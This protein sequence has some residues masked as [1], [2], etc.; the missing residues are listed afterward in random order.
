MKPKDKDTNMSNLNQKP[1]SPRTF[2]WGALSLRLKLVLGNTLITFLAVAGMGYYVYDRAQ[3]ANT[4]LSNQLYISVRQ[5]AEDK[6]T[7]TSIDEATALNNFFTSMSKDITTLGNTAQKLLSQEPLLNSGVYW[8][9][10]TALS[11]LPNGSWDN[12]NTEPASVFMPAKVDLSPE[13]T[14]E[15]NTIRQMDF[16]APTL[17]N[18]N[19]DAVAIYFG[20]VSGETIYYPNI[21]LASLVPA[22]F[23]VTQRP[24]FVAAT[25]IQDPDRKAVW[26]DPYL[27]A[28]RHG[29]IITVSTPVYDSGNNFRGVVAMDIQLNKITA[30]V[31]NIHVGDTGYAFLVDRGNRLIAMPDNAY[32]DLGITQSM[33]PLGQ[34][35][36][37]AHLANVNIPI[38]FFDIIHRTISGSTGL[39][40]M[41]LGGSER[42]VVYRPV[43]EVG[44]GLIIVVPSQEL[45]AGSI[46]AQA[47]IAQVTRNTLT[48][49]IFLVAGILILAL[50]ATLEIGN[51][52]TIP[53]RTL[54]K[55]AQEITGGNLEAVAVVKEQDEIGTLAKSINT[56]TSTL[57]NLIQSLE[58]R[59]K[60]RTGDLEVATRSAERRAAQFEAIARVTRAISSIHNTSEL[61]P[62][63]ASL[64]SE[65][66]GFYHVGIFLNDEDN[67]L[68]ILSASNSEGGQRMLARS[69]SLVI[70]EQGIV[71]YVASTGKTR[72]ARKVGEDAVFFDNPDLPETKSEMALPLRSAGKVVGVLDVQSRKEDAFSPE[73]ISVLAVLADQVSLAIDSA[74]LFDSTRRSLSEAETI[75]RQY[76]RQAWDRLPRERQLAGFRYSPAGA[77]PLERPLDAWEDS[78]Q[79]GGKDNYSSE[80]QFMVPIKL[81]GETIGNLIVRAPSNKKWSQDQI[82]LIT[83][84]AERVALSAEN[85]RLFDETSRRAERER[86][87][88]DITSKIRSTN[89]PQEMIR[90]ALAELRN[91]LGASQVQLIPQSVSTQDAEKDDSQ[92]LTQKVE[93]GNGA[94]K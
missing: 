94:E 63:I 69:H 18:E 37:Q 33:V 10:T 57:R 2:S 58:Q 3:Q 40:I 88:T 72:I 21:N 60:E 6:L 74:R 26:S 80:A 52:L 91:A 81:R 76:L 38:Q 56:M 78:S 32:N 51:R 1:T 7:T 70:G 68:A 17:L 5:Q 15:L 16:I 49:S 28:A 92:K 93:R 41:T 73:D 9:A 50:L 25:P 19:P 67:R 48:T 22:L 79:I 11:R 66:F 77:K 53:L 31:S 90:I 45:L 54:T 82:D 8:N 30:L 24:W 35:L 46:T 43:Q 42:F 47:Q 83:A 12:S 86:M 44:Y 29:L 27:D 14:S 61:L 34:P 89:D 23:D 39:T 4:Y 36:D 84:V 59:V 85:A 64:I 13:L 87:V 71:G 75:Y 55:T 20:G 65:Y 62:N